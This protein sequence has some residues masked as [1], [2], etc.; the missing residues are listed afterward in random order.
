MFDGFSLFFFVKLNTAIL[1]SSFICLFT[2]FSVLELLSSLIVYKR[3]MVGT[4]VYKNHGCYNNIYKKIVVATSDH[5]RK[6]C[7]L[8]VIFKSSIITLG[9]H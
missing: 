6:D 3:I 5:T 7:W 4:I 2:H 8:S 1:I 9:A